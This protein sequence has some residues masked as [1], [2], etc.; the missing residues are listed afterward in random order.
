MDEF[1]N[2][3]KIIELCFWVDKTAHNVYIQFS[4][5]SQ[6][7]KLRQEW[8]DRA[9]E[10][11]EHILFW[12][13]ALDLS[14][15][16]R[17]PLVLKNP[18]K[19]LSKMKKNQSSLEGILFRFKDYSKPE[20]QLS[21]A[22]VLESY[23]LSPAF[24]KLFHDYSFIN[25][26]IEREYQNHIL[27]FINMINN[28]RNK[29]SFLIVDLFCENL[30]ELYIVT[31]EYLENSI[32]DILT[33]LYNR[34]GFVNKTTSMLSGAGKEKLQIGI[35]MIDLDDFKSINDNHGHQTGD[36]ALQA[37]ATILK[38]SLNKPGI[39]GR[40]GGDEFIIC[41]DVKDLNCLKDLCKQIK[42]NIQEKS[43]VFAGV[44][45]TLSMGGATGFFETSEHN[46]LLLAEIISE[47]DKKLFDAK[48]KGKNIWIV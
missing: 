9:S 31:M 34:R 14:L 3:T 10:E 44:P 46:E 42:N 36:I 17:L 13:K 29:L 35:I 24:L 41:I 26:K 4:K 37:V 11:R 47:A 25:P 18:E 32:R 12:K 1:K 23:M 43:Q 19:T 45:F 28:F 21:L 27:T 33:G 40:Y 15:Q 6:N 7:A 20:E 5:S 48:R 30:F 8:L 16:K 2:L 38:S 39:I 22:F